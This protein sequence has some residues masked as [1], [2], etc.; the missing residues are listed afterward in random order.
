MTVGDEL[1]LLPDEVQYIQESQSLD[2]PKSQRAYFNNTD[3]DETVLDSA[4]YHVIMNTETPVDEIYLS[5]EYDKN[6]STHRRARDDPTY[7]P[8]PEDLTVD[9]HLLKDLKGIV[10]PVERARMVKA[11]I[12]EISDLCAIGTFELVRVPLDRKPVPS[13]LVLKVKYLADGTYNKHK[14]RLVAKGFMQ[15]LGVDFF[16]VFSPMATL[17][18][19]R[20]LFALAVSQGHDIFHADIPQAF[21]QSILDVDVWMSL[22]DGV[23]VKGPDGSENKVVKLIRS[24][25]G[26]R[27]APQLWNKALTSFFINTMGYTQASSDGCLFYKLT[28]RGYVLV[29]CEVDDL[30]ITGSDADAINDLHQQLISTY[31][32]SPIG[33]RFHRSSAST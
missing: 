16:S 26:L 1:D 19:V 13:R 30:V 10:D 25:Y 22:P 23:T 20:V 29:A 12:K 33:I 18:T 8:K 2:V 27:N 7:K 17:T 24:L 21:V 15:R 5:V 14:A 11:I 9:E 28:A 3:V 32:R 4:I 31:T 6:R